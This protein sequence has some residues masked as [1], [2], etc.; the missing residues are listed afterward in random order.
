MKYLILLI[1]VVLIFILL[2]IF[3]FFFKSNKIK[4]SSKV[5]EKQPVLDMKTIKFIHIGKCGGSTIRQNLTDIQYYHLSREYDTGENYIIWIRNPIHR[6]VSAFYYVKNLI[7]MN[8]DNINIED[9]TFQNYFSPPEIIR[10][11]QNGQVYS[12][13]YEKLVCSFQTVN[14]LA[15]SIYETNNP[16]KMEKAQ[17]LMNSMEEHIFKGIG[18]YLCNGDF[19]ERNYKNIIFVGT[20]ENMN[21]DLKKLGKLLRKKMNLNYALRKNKK[22]NNKFLSPKAIK[23]IKNFYKNTDYK[24]LEKLL[25]YGFITKKL[26]DEY[27]RYKI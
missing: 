26:L 19:V 9:V 16:E 14:E 15:E 7:E 13:E 17:K 5:K 2:V 1:Q 3:S 27:Q 8:V 20:H 21:S 24:A 10:K 6:F 4:S 22:S 12:K 25:K 18:W 23:N 11:I